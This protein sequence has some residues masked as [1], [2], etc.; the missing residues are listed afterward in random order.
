[1]NRIFEPMVTA[2][3]DGQ[4]IE[5]LTKYVTHHCWDMTETL[6]R[7]SEPMVDTYIEKIYNE[8]MVKPM[9]DPKE[10]F[11]TGSEG[12]FWPRKLTHLQILFVLPVFALCGEL[13]SGRGDLLVSQKILT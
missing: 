8:P 5:N 6:L 13:I 7:L 3:T 10:F 1:M 12:T 2:D 4:H 9:G 11:L